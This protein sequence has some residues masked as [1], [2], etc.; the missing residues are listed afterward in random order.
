MKK[1]Y[2]LL[3]TKKIGIPEWLLWIIYLV[4]SNIIFISI[5]LI[6]LIF[7]A[8]RFGFNSNSVL[9]ISY[10]ISAAIIL[11]FIYDIAPRFKLFFSICWSIILCVLFIGTSSG[12]SYPLSLVST[13]AEIVAVI[14]YNIFLY[15]GKK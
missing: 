4:L 5:G 11:T 15:S 9:H 3:D 10:F 13:I 12:F 7:I 14:V 2:V 1:D 6:S 8:Y